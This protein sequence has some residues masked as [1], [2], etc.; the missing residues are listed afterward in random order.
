MA[1]SIV[2]GIGL[3]L[4][5][6]AIDLASV[7]VVGAFG[8]DCWPVGDLEMMASV[9][10]FS[11]IGFRVGKITGV[12]RD[13]A[14]AGVLA[15]VIVAAIAIAVSLLLKPPAALIDTPNEMIGI[16]AQKVAIGGILAIVSGWLGK[17]SR[18][19]DSRLR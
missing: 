10:L 3:G 12:V 14:E 2:W 4:V 6:A 1:P 13:A 8:P 9:I 16:V 7:L 15:G 11:L 5:I 18:Q 19:V 17:Q